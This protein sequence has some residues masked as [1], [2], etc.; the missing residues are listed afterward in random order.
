M[1]EKIFTFA[2]YSALINAILVIPFFILA[3]FMDRIKETISLPLNYT[4]VI[5]SSLIAIILY[6][7][8]IL[9]FIQIGKDKKMKFFVYFLITSLILFA[10]DSIL[11]VYTGFVTV[12]PELIT[13]LFLIFGDIVNF[14]LAI[15]LIKL[16]KFYEI[17]KYIGILIIVTV[18]SSLINTLVPAVENLMFAGIFTLSIFIYLILATIIGILE[19]KL[20]SKLVEK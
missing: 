17:L 10:L 6:L 18:F 7:F 1:N 14:I 12:I 9:G 3:I 16:S 4:I 19:F 13:K 11:G 20:F 15:Y 5:I 2:K 8:I